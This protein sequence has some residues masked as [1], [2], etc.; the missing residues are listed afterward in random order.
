MLGLQFKFHEYT[1]QLL[2]NMGCCT[3][4]LNKVQ[5]VT[6]DS[7]AAPQFNA[8]FCEESIFHVNDVGEPYERHSVLH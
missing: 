4:C 1:M 8:T 7:M 3:T 6:C 5:S 2:H